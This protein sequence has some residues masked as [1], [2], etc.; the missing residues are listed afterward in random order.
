MKQTGKFHF[1]AIGGS[2]MHN[3]AIALKQAGHHVTGSDDELTDPSR[4]ALA[5]HGLLPPVKG[6]QPDILDS[7]YTAV[8]VGMHAK[9]NNPELVKALHLGLKLYSFPEFIFEHSRDKQRIVVAGSHGKTTITAIIL[10]VLAF[11]QR[12]FDYVIGARV[13]GLENAVKL[14]DAPL[15]VIEGDEYLSSPIDPTPKF[16]KYQHHIGVISGISWDHV[17]VFSTEEEY[18]RQF[19]LFADATPKGGI[20]VYCETDPVATLVCKKERPDVLYVPYKAHPHTQEGGR[21]FLISSNKERLP[22]KIFGKHNLQNISAAREVLKKIGITNE[23]FDQAI[24][25]FN[26]AAGRLEKIFESNGV[27]IFKDFAHAPSKVKATTEAVKELYPQ[28]ELVA[29]VEL[30]TYSSLTKKFLPQYKGT[31][32]SANHAFVYFNP[33]KVKAKGL[34]AF[35]EADVKQGFGS[36]NVE[37]FTDTAQLTQR[38]SGMAWKNRNLL[39]MSSGTFN[40]LD[41]ARLAGD[42]EA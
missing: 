17:N 19:D 3:L 41:F 11:H 26:G 31:L 13:A 18:I 4:S 14:S 9:A 32:K 22:L 35:T 29:C 21:E 36:G 10:H 42:L 15:I 25:S 40:G 27:V 23:Q 16:L 37:V 28:R 33:D 12:Y 20:I 30:H 39:A 8:V 7:S 24:S 6:W 2:V 38:L 34:E 1:I 5:Q